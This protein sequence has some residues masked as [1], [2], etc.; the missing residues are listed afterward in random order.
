MGEEL[1]YGTESLGGRE[2][3]ELERACITNDKREGM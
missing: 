1:T 2:G 3:E